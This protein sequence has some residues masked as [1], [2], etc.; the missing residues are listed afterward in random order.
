MRADAD[1]RSADAE[2]NEADLHTDIRPAADH[3]VADRERVQRD[4]RSKQRNTQSADR[5]LTERLRERRTLQRTGESSQR[6][7]IGTARDRVAELRHQAAA[8]IESTIAP[9]QLTLDELDASAELRERA[10]IAR[11]AAAKARRSAA[12]ERARDL[13]QAA[14]VAIETS[15]AQDQGSGRVPAER[16]ATVADL[17]PGAVERGELAL[18]YQPLRDLATSQI[19][20]FEALLRWTNPDLGRVP[21]DHFIPVA[22]ASGQIVDLGAWVLEHALATLRQWRDEFGRESPEDGDGLKVNPEKI[23]DALGK[24]AHLGME[25]KMMTGYCRRLW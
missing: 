23:A 1:Q 9:A 14:G 17:L 24:A 20:G 5:A 6:D 19:V 3:K 7:V 22:E 10:A 8:R 11:T 4:R 2:Q 15:R 16:R 12:A 13:I 25:A 21:P 18:N